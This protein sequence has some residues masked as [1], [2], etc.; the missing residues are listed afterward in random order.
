MIVRQYDD[1]DDDDDEGHLLMVEIGICPNTHLHI[2]KHKHI[3]ISK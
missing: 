3:Y 1:D 2:S